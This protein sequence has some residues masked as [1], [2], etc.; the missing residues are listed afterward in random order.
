MS[1]Y[2]LAAITPLVAGMV[3]AIAVITGSAPAGPQ[4]LP[5]P[6]LAPVGP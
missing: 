3:I 1:I 5:L 4:T 2:V 6:T